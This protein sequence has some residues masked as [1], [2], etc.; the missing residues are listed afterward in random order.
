MA[1]GEPVDA[2]CSSE[3]RPSHEAWAR[4]RCSARDTCAATPVIVG[5]AMEG[6][7]VLR[8]GLL[9]ALSDEI[10]RRSH[11]GFLTPNRSSAH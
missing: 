11:I 1:R 3:K 7:V 2:G 6:V 10:Q 9:M 5:V 4:G 8:A